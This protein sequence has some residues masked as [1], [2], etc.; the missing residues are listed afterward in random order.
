LRLARR[1]RGK[2]W[3][4]MCDGSGTLHLHLDSQ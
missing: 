1:D 2:N 3:Q 4:T